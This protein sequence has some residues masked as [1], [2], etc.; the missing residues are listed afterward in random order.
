MGEPTQSEPV[1]SPRRAPRDHAAAG[2]VARSKVSRSW[3][4]QALTWALPLGDGLL[5]PLQGAQ[6]AVA[7]GRGLEAEHLGGLLVA[8]HLEVAE[9]EDLAVDGVHGVEGLLNAELGL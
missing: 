5:E 8:Q 6:M 1:P 7:R 4:W 9:D 3:S 2:P